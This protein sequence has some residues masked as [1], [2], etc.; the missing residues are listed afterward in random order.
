MLAS[1][2]TNERSPAGRESNPTAPIE[3]QEGAA[4]DALGPAP[5]S[6]PGE[7]PGKPGG[8][9]DQNRRERAQALVDAA[10]ALFLAQGIEGTTIDE[11]TKAAGVSKGSFYR[12]FED[13][14][15]LVRHAF[16]PLYAEVS[17]AF[18]TC[19]EALSEARSTDAMMAIYQD[20]GAELAGSILR[21][22]ELVLLYLQESRAPAVGARVPLV[23]L[24]Q[25]ISERAVVLT[26]VAHQHG[27]LR[28]FPDR[29]SALTVVG[30]SERLIFALLKE[31]EL[32]DDPL[33]L[34]ELV[35]SLILDGL[36]AR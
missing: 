15:Q 20:L 5:P 13:K 14:L 25:L 26:E 9:R 30:A 6:V 7:R 34:P 12:Y 17:A 31:E 8:K 23:E 16:A 1:V 28:S 35:A 11:I 22:S 3:R 29:V 4:A 18:D 27:V 32:L 19:G 2:N 24:A 36:A 33:K 21:Y 10:V